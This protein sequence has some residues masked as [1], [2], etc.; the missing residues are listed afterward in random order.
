MFACAQNKQGETLCFT[1]GQ[2][3]PAIPSK[4]LGGNF[5]IGLGATIVGVPACLTL[6]RV[7]GAWVIAGS[8]SDDCAVLCVVDGMHAPIALAGWHSTLCNLETSSVDRKLEV[9]PKDLSSIHPAAVVVEVCKFESTFHGR[10]PPAF[11]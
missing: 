5:E 4:R 3:A 2:S 10:A 1:L 9:Q 11:A 6:V 7:F 8:A